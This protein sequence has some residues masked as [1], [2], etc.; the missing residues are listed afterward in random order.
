MPIRVR[1]CTVH[2]MK[3]RR[4]FLLAAIALQWFPLHVAA[5]SMFNHTYAAWD[6]LLRKH[7]KLIND[8]RAS[9]VDYRGF[10][11]ER[12]ALAAYL[13][14]LSAV[15]PAQYTG[16]SKPQQYAFLANAY[17]AFT[18]E[19]VLTRYPNLKS[20]RDFGTVV[21][22]PWKD[23]FFTLLGK[24]QHLDGIEHDTM[25]AP[26]AF[27]DPRVHVAVNCASVGC[28]MLS[29]RALTPDKIDAQL[30]D[31]FTRFMSDRSRNRYNAQTRTVEL[32]R[33]FDW[34]GKDFDKGHKG[35]SSVNDVVAKYA[36][37]LADAPDDRA[38][39]R[40]GKVPLRFLEY[41][42]SLNDVR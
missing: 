42:W 26:G 3:P 28:P 7:V 11:Q 33:I 21:G 36:D 20:I 35:F 8:G 13:Q 6:A 40:S 30:D 32:S 18:I 34:Y 41:D 24:Q 29:N 19:K 9:Q 23:R 37:Q 10:A 5:Q 22:N 38:Q 27:D 12:A 25:R 1:R 4:R 17:N 39:L 2:C 16:W 31:L 15:T 14:S